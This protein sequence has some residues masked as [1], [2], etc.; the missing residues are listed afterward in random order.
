MVGVGSVGCIDGFR[1]SNVQIDLVKETPAQAP[2][3]AVPRADQL[4]SNAHFTIYAIQEAADRDHLFAL[5]R[6]EIH[7]I[8]DLASP[9]FIDVGDHV[10]HP[11]LHVSQ[12]S[13]Q[14]GIDTGITDIRNPPAGATEEQKITAA[15]AE[16]RMENITLLGGDGGIKAV[17][18]ASTTPYP[19]VATDCNGPA[20][21]IPPPMCTDEASNQR[22]LELC[23]ATWS[24]DPGLWEG[25]DRVLT[26]P[27]AGTTFG[28][29]DGM[30]P[31]NTAPVGGAQFFV[32]EALAGIDAY[33]IYWQVDGMADPGNLLLFGRPTHPTRGVDYVH[34]T[35]LQ[36]PVLSANLVIFANLGEDTVHF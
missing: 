27:L 15:T 28:L 7:P 22:R 10:P 8:V 2:P 36:S 13:K 17:T 16:K 34:L 11:G 35:S 12:F 31:I 33:A 18:S 5:D 32:D 23:Q 26:A 4:P 24:S 25:T 3:G 21:Q 19:I 6:F 20:S 30:N 1:G 14:I 29:V 9:C